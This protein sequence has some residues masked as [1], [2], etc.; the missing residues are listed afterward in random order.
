MTLT[1]NN[2]EQSRISSFLP[3]LA[4]AVIAGC[5][6][7]ACT[8][9]SKKIHGVS[10]TAFECPDRGGNFYAWQ[11]SGI[12]DEPAS[13]NE[14]AS[15][16]GMTNGIITTDT[17]YIEWLLGNF[18]TAGLELT[19]Q[20]AKWDDYTTPDGYFDFDA[21][22]QKIR[23]Y[24]SLDLSGFIE[25]GTF[26]G[27]VI[28]DDLGNFTDEGPDSAILDQMAA[29]VKE[30]F[31]I[32]TEQDFS[33]IVRH[34]PTDMLLKHNGHKFMYVNRVYTQITEVKA[35][36]DLENFIHEQDTAAGELGLEFPV[37]GVNVLDWEFQ[38]SSGNCPSGHDG[39]QVDRCA[40]SPEGLEEVTVAIVEQ[41]CNS[42]T[43]VWKI[44]DDWSFLFEDS[45]LDAFQGLAAAAN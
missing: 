33:L 6:A 28:L 14:V 9:V 40:I 18:E 26:A 8:D 11:L 4:T 39:Y 38:D 24:E 32:S 7:T 30:V 15:Q 44:S 45:Y 21:W 3:K 13:L 25:D 5:L 29:V 17:E 16:T 36:D 37:F 31:N 35:G 27:V 23:D 10:D 20:L 34:D 1:P 19:P 42:G 2:E 12:Y 41:G 22:E 43:S